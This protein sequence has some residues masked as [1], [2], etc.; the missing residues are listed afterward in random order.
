MRLQADHDRHVGFGSNLDLVPGP[1][2]DRKRPER[3]WSI[4]LFVQNETGWTD[5]LKPVSQQRMERV[6]V[7]AQLC[8]LGACTGRLSEG[9]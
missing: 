7:A 3:N 4:L 9:R 2:L 8:Q 5:E 6:G 1:R